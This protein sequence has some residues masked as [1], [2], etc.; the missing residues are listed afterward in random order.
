MTQKYLFSTLV[1][2]SNISVACLFEIMP[3][4]GA[5]KAKLRFAVVDLS[6]LGRIMKMDDRFKGSSVCGVDYKWYVEN[7]A[8]H[9]GGV[10]QF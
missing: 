6:V 10:I 5:F 9:F 4:F 8:K 3:T 1:T 2:E 7:E